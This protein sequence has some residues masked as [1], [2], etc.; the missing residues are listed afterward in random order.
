MAA[1]LVTIHPKKLIDPK[2]ARTVGSRKTPEPIITPTDMA[3]DFQNPILGVWTSA[4]F[5]SEVKFS[6]NL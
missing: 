5:S 2:G 3:Q 6:T 4:R 1:E